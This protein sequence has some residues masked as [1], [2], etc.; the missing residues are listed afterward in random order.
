MWSDSGKPRTLLA[1]DAQKRRPFFFLRMCLSRNHL[2]LQCPFYDLWG[3]C[4]R[5]KRGPRTGGRSHGK[6]WGHRERRAVRGAFALGVRTGGWL[7]D[8]P[9]QSQ[10]PGYFLP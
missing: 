10:G 6:N 8:T 1:R 3:D 5:A 7:L 4:V 9:S 2:E